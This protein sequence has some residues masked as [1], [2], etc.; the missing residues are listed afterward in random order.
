MRPR[1]LI[2]CAL[3]MLVLLVGCLWPRT[4]GGVNWSR[5]FAGP[6]GADVVAVEVAVLEVPAGDHYVNAELWSAVDDQILPADVRQRLEENGLRVAKVSG[7]PPD[8]LQDLL[9]SERSNRNARHVRVRSNNLTNVPLGPQR[10]ICQFRLRGDG[11]DEPVALEQAQC[12]LQ[13]TPVIAGE[14]KVNL[15][16]LPQIQHADRKRQGQL[17]PTIALGLQ[18]SRATESYPAMRWEVPL[19]LNEYVLVGTRFDKSQ[20]LGFR[21]FLTSEGE[22]PMQRLLAI[23]GGRVGSA[24]EESSAPPGQSGKPRPLA[25]QA[26][27]ALAI[28]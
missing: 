7:R 6:V 12:N 4:T 9:L 2:V 17:I 28:P 11:S 24:S 25:A 13:V 18:G 1:R 10:D 20:S 19:G 8:G 16:F 27:A 14:G 23:R 5:P 15:Q 21:F 22:K 26:A 3:P